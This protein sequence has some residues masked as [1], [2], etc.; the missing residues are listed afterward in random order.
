MERIK[1]Q[2]PSIE[3]IELEAEKMMIVGSQGGGLSDGGQDG[4]SMGGSI[5]F[6][7]KADGIIS[8]NADE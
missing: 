3:I 5:Q 8:D 2:A 6:F 1:Y 4:P 7:K